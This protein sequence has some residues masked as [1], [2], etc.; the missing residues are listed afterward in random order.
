MFVGTPGR[1][2]IETGYELWMDQR[3]HAEGAAKLVWIDLETQRSAPLPEA[4]VAICA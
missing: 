1:S 4:L 3:K 2:S